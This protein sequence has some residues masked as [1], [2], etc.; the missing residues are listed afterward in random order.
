MIKSNREVYNKNFT[1]AKYQTF[2]D[3][4]ASSFNYVPKF[5]I[6]ETPVFIPKDLKTKLIA[7]CNDIIAVINQPNFKELTNASVFKPSPISQR[8]NWTSA[9]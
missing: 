1:E 7:A 5:K 4:I 6:S 9:R 3:D 2:L 8:Q